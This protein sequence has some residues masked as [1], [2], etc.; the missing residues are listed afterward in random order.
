MVSVDTLGWAREL[1]IG[2]TRRASAHAPRI[3]SRAARQTSAVLFALLRE[4]GDELCHLPF[5]GEGCALPGPLGTVSRL[6]RPLCS[7]VE[8]FPSVVG[9]R[10][11]G[12]LAR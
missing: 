10:V 12:N 9:N 8:C 2:H 11:G 6:M 5:D 1:H 4:Q 7:S 3:G